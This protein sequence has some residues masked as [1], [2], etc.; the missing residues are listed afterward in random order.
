MFLSDNTETAALLTGGFIVP[1]VELQTTLDEDR[2]AF[3]EILS[4][5]L[6]GAPPEG[7][8]HI[9]D[10]LNAF[11]VVTG[12]NPVNG[13]PQ[14]SNCGSFRGITDFRIA[15]EV[16]EKHDFIDAGHND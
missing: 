2:A 16:P 8:V 14:I 5:E 15:G 13:H 6:S 10:F 4:S 9:G 7:D 12:T 1:L 3:A 11:P